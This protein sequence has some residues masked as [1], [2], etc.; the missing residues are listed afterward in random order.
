MVEAHLGKNVAEHMKRWASAIQAHDLE[1]VP[2]EILTPIPEGGL[3]EAAQSWVS[4]G[5]NLPVTADQLQAALGGDRIGALAQ[6][7]GLDPGRQRASGLARAGRAVAGAGEVAGKLRDLHGRLRPVATD[8]TVRAAL[9]WWQLAK[10][11][12]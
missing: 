8:E 1:G 4:T 12:R 2:A 5:Q 3:G 6:Q 11:L 10:A 7:V 9:G